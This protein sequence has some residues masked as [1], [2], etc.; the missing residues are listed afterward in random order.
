MKVRFKDSPKEVWY[1]GKFN[2]HG[3]SEVIVQ[4]TELGAD[5]V[6]IKDL[7]ILLASGEWKDMSQAFK[8]HDLIVD[9]YNT[10]FFEPRTTE[11]R[12]RG[13]AL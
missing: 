13:F 12:E 2:I 10:Y 8:G 3:L 1:S 4:H 6:F 5:S 7:E 9:N 11:E